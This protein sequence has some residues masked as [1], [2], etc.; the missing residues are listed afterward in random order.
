MSDDFLESRLKR[1]ARAAG[2]SGPEGLE[3]GILQAV[4]AA[5]GRP[6]RGSRRP[7]W[8][9][10]LTG[11]VAAA[12]TVALTEHLQ[13]PPAR[14]ARLSAPAARLGQDPWPVLAAGNPL[15]R[16]SAAL[17]RQAQRAASYLAAS[18]TPGESRTP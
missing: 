16:E 17:Q 11:A 12:A 4:E 5:R 8:A 18:F 1:E 7:L 6:T 14:P 10:I 2:G 13:A 15:E 9:L 3:R